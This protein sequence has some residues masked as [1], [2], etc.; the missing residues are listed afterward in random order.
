MYV[1]YKKKLFYQIYINICY[2]LGV[3]SSMNKMLAHI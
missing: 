3:I 1:N 2:N